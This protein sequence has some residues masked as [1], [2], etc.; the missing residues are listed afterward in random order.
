MSDLTGEPTMKLNVNA[1][2]D[3]DL[4]STQGGSVRYI[5]VEVSAEGRV[6]RDSAMQAINLA[7]AIDVSGSMRGDRIAAARRT[8]SAIVAAL[9]ER[10]RLSLVAFNDT[11]V[12][13]LA[14]CVM[15]EAGRAVAKASIGELAAGGATNL[16]EGWM[17][18]AEAVARAMHADGRRSGRVVLLSDGHAN[19]GITGAQ[20][21]SRHVGALLERGVVTSAIGIEGGY[22]QRLLGSIAEAGGGGLHEAG[23]PDEIQEVVLGELR[24]G[25]GTVVERVRLSLALPPGFSAEVVGAW[26]NRMNGTTLEV[27]CGGLQLSQTRHIVIR[28]VCPAGEVGSK[29]PLMIRASGT[30]ISVDAELDAEAEGVLGFVASA[31]NETQVRDAG[32]GIVVARAWHN[33]IVRRAMELAVTESSEAAEAYVGI[34]RPRFEDYAQSV[35]G[36]DA[37]VEDMQL[38]WRRIGGG[39]DSRTSKSLYLSSYKRSRGE[40]DLRRD[41]GPTLRQYLSDREPP[42]S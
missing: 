32:R 20:E 21:I 15:D 38:L 36:A 35:P 23:T 41:A 40:R 19:Q 39:V 25:R 34:E 4:A 28:L 3:R 10:D 26:A 7:L 2:L 37:L 31:E 42:A 27:L 29:V 6:G 5:V 17:L 8:A 12:S 1:G 9:T 22:D 18:A 30:A 16:F 33:D 14:P 11:A 24:E 13:I